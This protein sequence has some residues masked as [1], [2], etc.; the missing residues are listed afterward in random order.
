MLRPNWHEQPG[1]V[2]ASDDGEA[3]YDQRLL[4]CQ[5]LACSI[6]VVFRDQ[7]STPKERESGERQAQSQRDPLSI[8][9]RPGAPEQP[10]TE[11]QCSRDL[12]RKALKQNAQENLSPYHH[13]CP[14]Q[15]WLRR[16]INDTTTSR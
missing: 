14:S 8:R 15:L 12:P 11:K 6:A 7:L 16:Y 5:R 4:A 10:A 2:D 3:H 1:Q 9:T 13:P